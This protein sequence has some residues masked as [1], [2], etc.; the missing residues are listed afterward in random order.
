MK[1]YELPK[2][3]DSF[4]RTDTKKRARYGKIW[5]PDDYARLHELFEGGVSLEAMCDELQ[6]P[7]N[8]I[9]TKLDLEGYIKRDPL[10]GAYHVLLSRPQE[11]ANTEKTMSTTKTIETKTL[12]NGKDA[13]EMSDRQIFTEIA[14]LEQEILKLSSINHKP[15][16]LVAAI[17]EMQSDIGKL[18]EFVDA[19]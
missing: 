6:R 4:T 17:A 9:L 7:A 3:D 19:R 11:T 15:K 18:V 8:G 13:S 1:L 10:T 2:F 16:K 12:I 14:R 5:T